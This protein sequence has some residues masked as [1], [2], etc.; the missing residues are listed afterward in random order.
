[1]KFK[2]YLTAILTVIAVIASVACLTA[3]GGKSDGNGGTAQPT[4]VVT[5]NADKPLNLEIGATVDFKQYFTV[6]DSGGNQIVVTDEMLDLTKADTS[7]AGTFTVTLT[8]GNVKKT[9]TFTVIDDDGGNG[10]D[11]ISVLAKYADRTTWN[12]ATTLSY[13]Y[14]GDTYSEYYEHNGNATKYVY[15]E[16]GDTYTDYISYDPTADTYY[17]YSEQNDGS[18]ARY[19]EGTDDFDQWFWYAAPVDL[20]EIKD[21][22]FTES[23]GV[24]TATKPND[25]GKSV[26]GEYTGISWTAFRVEIQF[27]NIHSITGEMSDGEKYVYVFSKHGSV[28][29]TLPNV[30]GTSD[31]PTT[32]TGTM[33]KQTYNPNDFDDERLQDKITKTGDEP[34]PAIGLSAIGK[35]HALVIPVQFTDDLIEDG[36]LAK[37]NVAFNGDTQSTGWQSVHSYYY[38][39]SYQKLD[40]TF[41]IAGY[42]IAQNKATFTA[43]S[44]DSAYYARQTATDPDTN[45]KYKNGDNLLLHEALK[46]YDDV[47]DFSDYDY[48]GDGTLDAVYL[49]YTADI[50]YDS[51]DSFYWAYVTW[52]YEDEQYDETN[53]FYYL[54][55][56]VD[57]MIESVKD[58]FVDEEYY[59]EISGLIVNASTYIHETGHLLG[60]DDYYD[61]DDRSGSNEGLGGADMM[62]A[63]VGD[64]NVYSKI[65]LGWVTPQIVVST[66]TVTI[67]SSQTQGDAILIPLNF[68]NSYFCEYLLIDLYSADG[69]N[70]MHASA[71]NSYLYDGKDYGV[72][73]YHVSS[74]IGN[75]YSTDYGSFTDN[76]N[77]DTSYA[78]IKLVEADGTKKFSNSQGYAADSDL[79]QAG[80]K[81]S[82]VFPNY[83]TNAGKKL[84]FDISIDS[85]SAAQATITITYAA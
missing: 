37:L 29:F 7:K 72:R 26:I 18:Y 69:L 16:D 45:Q 57:F 62:D 58:G 5:V 49:I 44:G 12:F 54:F 11:P 60:L 10:G 40:I 43:P 48:D 21:F 46:Y 59:P 77:T 53:V 55:A 42:N 52:N 36:E 74:S 64:Q 67:K 1:M 22:E 35:Y 27:G 73:I 20:S 79:W 78:L 83:T 34:D 51:D 31:T 76:N 23:N 9:V 84:N 80:Q 82:T 65:M 30:D 2:K 47:I 50:E 71:S 32:P 39:S 14:D 13:T 41:D 61:Y 38:Q 70:A 81:L 15:D 3:C 24:Y 85:V 33:D 8:V 68:N 6:K 66:K 17:Y 56:G 25:V 75:G 4:Y 63:T 28:S 19:A